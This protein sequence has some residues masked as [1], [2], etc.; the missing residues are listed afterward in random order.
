[1]KYLDSYELHEGYDWKEELLK[2]DTENKAD[3]IKDILTELTD[4]GISCQITKNY[5]DSNFIA[6][7]SKND[8]AKTTYYR[9]YIISITKNYNGANKVNPVDSFIEFNNAMNYVTKMLKMDFHQIMIYDGGH[10]F[11]IKA[12]DMDSPLDKRLVLSDK[13]LKNIKISESGGVYFYTERLNQFL[14]K[15]A[16]IEV[17][18]NSI[19]IH[20]TTKNIDFLL[21]IIKKMFKLQLNRKLIDIKELGNELRIDIKKV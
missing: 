5:A 18:K 21:P 7:N 1:M 14:S 10:S 2:S 9:E 17:I 8:L 12:L 19:I 4:I 16:R 15:F 13:Q 11:I 3:H 20:P 6:M